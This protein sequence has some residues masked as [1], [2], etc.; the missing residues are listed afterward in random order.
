MI[1]VRTSRRRIRAAGSWARREEGVALVVVLGIGAVLTV[2]V[3][4]ALSLSLSSVVKAQTDQDWNAAVA[5]AYAGVDD[6]KSKLANDSTY[7]QY[8]N[9]EAAFSATS[10]AAGTLVLP[11]GSKS[12]PAFGVGAAGTW[13]TI[14]GTG[15]PASYRYEVDNSK[16]SSTGVLR[17]R[18]TGRVGAQARSVVVN[19]KQSGF[20][21]FLYFSNY[22]VADPAL[23]GFDGTNGKPNC[24]KYEWQS[25][26]NTCDQI[27]FAGSDVINGPLHSNDTIYVCGATFNGPVTTATTRTSPR[28]DKPSS[29]CSTPTFKVPGSPAF[30]PV[31]AMPPSNGKMKDETRTDIRAQVP[32]P[33]CLYTGPTKVTFNADGTMT[34]RSPWTKATRVIGNPATAVGTPSTGD[35]PCGTPGDPSK[36]LAANANTLAGDTGQKIAVPANNLIYVQSVPTNSPSDP[37]YWTTTSAPRGVQCTSSGNGIGYP[38]ANEQVPTAAAGTQA[39]G[40]RN[41][42][43]FVQG[44]MRG[45]LTVSAANYIYVT[46]DITYQDS[47]ADILGLVAEN[48]VWVWNPMDCTAYTTSD[49]TAANPGNFTKLLSDSARRIDAA[50]LSVNH[51]FQVQNYN[52]GG[53]R[54][55]LTVNGAIAQNF[56]GPVGTSGGSGGTGYIKNY[57]YDQ[58]YR[59]IAPPKFIVP[60]S[61]TYGIS[62]QAEVGKAFNADGS[63]A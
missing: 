56:R 6:Y 57:L 63:P 58:R 26:S 5:A 18:A 24:A 53:K 3:T 42:D 62:V 49:C 13:A 41:G 1:G 61:T 51:T 7:V 4:A 12:N 33:G 23:T 16:Y 32:R 31:I 48:A 15:A 46:G 17:L 36:T 37:N 34:I 44:T 19:L 9:Q 20:I 55:T 59:N 30:A 11:T 50:I 22:E 45:A 25:R 39:Y 52:L 43:V 35:S 47:K 28:Y 2:L 10:K 14:A 27:Q 29:G 40:C 38:L 60:P 8:G 54:G 21:D